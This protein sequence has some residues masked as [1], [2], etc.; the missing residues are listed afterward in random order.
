MRCQ[1]ILLVA[2][3]ERVKRLPLLKTPHFKD[4]R[5]RCPSLYSSLLLKITVTLKQT[6][7]FSRNQVCSFGES[8]LRF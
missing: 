2:L 7:A 5:S 1:R 4:P 8:S 3:W 6:S